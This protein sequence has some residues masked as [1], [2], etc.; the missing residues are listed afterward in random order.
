M[1]FCT[2]FHH[3]ISNEPLR[4]GYTRKY[5]VYVICPCSSSLPGISRL[6]IK[7]P[8]GLLAIEPNMV[9]T[10]SCV[11]YH[12]FPSFHSPFSSIH[13]IK[14]S[15][16]QLTVDNPMAIFTIYPQKRYLPLHLSTTGFPP[17]AMSVPR[18]NV[19]T[20]TPWTL[21]PSK[22]VVRLTECSLSACIVMVCRKS[23]IVMSASVPFCS[24]PF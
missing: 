4:R 6:F 11:S 23:I 22:G 24:D 3:T 21:K 16:L 10:C 20:G 19:A 2:V 13:T 14:G 1:P 12:V 17:L 7:N 8:A 18:R 9:F 5:P 15:F